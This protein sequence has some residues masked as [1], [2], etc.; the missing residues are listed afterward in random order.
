MSA[1]DTL[2][3][4]ANVVFFLVWVVVVSV[5]VIATMRW[6]VRRSASRAMEARVGHYAR[7]VRPRRPID[8]SWASIQRSVR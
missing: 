5:V 4:A 7:P 2:I 6:T 1:V 8:R 3:L